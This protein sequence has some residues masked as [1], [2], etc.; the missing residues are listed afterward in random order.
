MNLISNIS[1]VN[2]LGAELILDNI[3]FQN[4]GIRRGNTPPTRISDGDIGVFQVESCHPGDIIQ[5]TVFYTFTNNQKEYTLEVYF[6]HTNMREKSVYYAS[7]QPDNIIFYNVFPPLNTR[8]VQA[9]SI[10][11]TLRC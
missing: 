8:D 5:G 10:V 3:T 6:E 7:S 11:V 1:I 9:V 4:G 2:D